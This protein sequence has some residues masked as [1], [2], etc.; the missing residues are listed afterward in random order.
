[1]VRFAAGEGDVLIATNIIESGLDVPRAN[2]ILIWDA[3]RFGLAQLHQLRGRVGRG[4]RRGTAYLL[5]DPEAQIADAT[6]KRLEAL[7]AL[8]RLGAGF[9]VG[10]EDLDS[11]GAGDLLGDTQAGH[12]KLIGAGLYRRLLERALQIARGRTPADEWVPELNLGVTIRIPEEYV[13]EP[14]VRLGL[15]A[16]IAR[17]R[18]RA[19]E[20]RL[21]D[22]I[23]DRFG[24][25]PPGI[26]DLFALARLRR[27]CRSTDVMRVDAGPQAVALT[28]KNGRPDEERL[29]SLM[30]RYRGDLAWKGE[31]LILSRPMGDSQRLSGAETL[32]DD[33]LSA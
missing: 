3:D 6:R 12:V 19:G 20:R 4:Q 27:L 17:S 31:R 23:D 5:T 21:A 9:E 26:R 1:M 8:D 16:R 22:E 15:Y 2:T 33:L 29:S 11:R 14:D 18:D 24:P 13:P 10:A 25:P 30:R 32:L 7:A 28:F